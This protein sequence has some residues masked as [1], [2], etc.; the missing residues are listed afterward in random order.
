MPLNKDFVSTLRMGS[1]LLQ[2]Q[3]TPLAPSWSPTDKTEIIAII[4]AQYHRQADQ[5]IEALILSSNP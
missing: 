2:E 1:P 3:F 4:L 5:F